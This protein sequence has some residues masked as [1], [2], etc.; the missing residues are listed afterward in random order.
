MKKTLSHFV[1]M[2]AYEAYLKGYNESPA[3]TCS[4]WQTADTPPTQGSKFIVV[5]DGGARICI[6]GSDAFDVLQSR[7][8]FL[9]SESLDAVT[10][11]TEQSRSAARMSLLHRYVLDAKKPRPETIRARFPRQY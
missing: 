7:R 1:S 5:E 8:L 6:L 3:S 2:E 4:V 9:G 11:S 10:R